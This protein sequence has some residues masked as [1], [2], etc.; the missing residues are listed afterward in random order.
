MPAHQSVS[1]LQSWPVTRNGASASHFGEHF[2]RAGYDDMLHTKER[3][4]RSP[5]VESAQE[6]E[7]CFFLSSNRGEIA[8]YYTFKKVEGEIGHFLCVSHIHD[9]SWCVSVQ[10]QQ[11]QHYWFSR[12]DCKLWRSGYRL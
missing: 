3:S 7:Q 5:C 12:S 11:K 2:K 4:D 6:E 1:E 9:C 8:F 10:Q